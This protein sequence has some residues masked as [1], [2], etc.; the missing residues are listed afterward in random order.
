VQRLTIN[1]LSTLVPHSDTSMPKSTRKRDAGKVSKEANE[2]QKKRRLLACDSCRRRKVKCDSVKPSCSGCRRH[3]LVCHYQTEIR[4]R[5]S[6]VNYVE[7][8][9]RKVELMERILRSEHGVDWS[10]KLLP[11]LSLPDGAMKG[12]STHDSSAAHLVAMNIGSRSTSIDGSEMSVL[13]QA[14]ATLAGMATVPAMPPMQQHTQHHLVSAEMAAPTIFAAPKNVTTSN[15]MLTAPA[16]DLTEVTPELRDHLLGLYFRYVAH[17]HFMFDQ[18]T[19]YVQ[20]T[21][22]RI[23]PALLYSMHAIAVRFTQLPNVASEER[24][25]AGRGYA[26]RA[27]ME[28]NAQSTTTDLAFVHLCIHELGCRGSS[29][30][31]EQLRDCIR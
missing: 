20:L 29:K 24:H 2:K 18:A 30:I 4:K 8:L 22:G 31:W 1:Y 21:Q 3:G 15:A 11:Y 6:R 28:L 16:R 17:H 26:L 10:S 14:P 12:S 25:M 27:Q 7:Q 23:P 19:F 13:T 9:E 5:G